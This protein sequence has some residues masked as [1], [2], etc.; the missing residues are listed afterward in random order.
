MNTKPTHDSNGGGNA[1]TAF[2]PQPKG[3]HCPSIHQPSS[4]D[5]KAVINV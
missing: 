5:R 4:Y 3:L 2:G 1:A